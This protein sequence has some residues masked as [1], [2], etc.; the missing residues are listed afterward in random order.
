MYVKQLKRKTRNLKRGLKRMTRKLKRNLGGNM[1]LSLT[2]GLRNKKGG[3]RSS[4][5]RKRSSK[6][7]SSSKSKRSS[8][9][10]MNGGNCMIGAPYNAADLMPKGN[11]LP[12]NPRVEAWPEQ[13]NAIF[14][15]GKSKKQ[16]KQRGGGI[17]ST[18]M[19]DELVNFSRHVPATLGQMYDSFNGTTSPASSYVYPTNQPLAAVSVAASAGPAQSDLLKMYQQNNNSVARI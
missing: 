16:K 3:K 7:S 10:K 18:L 1:T 14:K 19:P 8:Q 9:K 6:S 5:K 15:G 4:S 17:L 13:S 11:Y 12:Y 2:I